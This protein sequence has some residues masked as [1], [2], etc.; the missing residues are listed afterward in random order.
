MLKPHQILFV[1]LILTLISLW[2]RPTHSDGFSPRLI[3]SS[4]SKR[5]NISHSGTSKLRQ[6]IGYLPKQVLPLLVLLR[7]P[8]L[9]LALRQESFLHPL[10]PYFTSNGQLRILSSERSSDCQI[11]VADNLRDGYRY[12]RCDHTIL[13]GRWIQ[14]A[15]G[16]DNSHHI[17]MGDS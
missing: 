16:S 11:V 7:L 14:K 5:F 6:V 15:P 10:P 12:L 1:S 3:E 2:L 4:I 17:D 13:G 9:V 8:L